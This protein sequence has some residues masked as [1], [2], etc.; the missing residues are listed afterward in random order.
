MQVMI[1]VYESGKVEHTCNLLADI[2]KKG[3]VTNLYDY[4]GN[5]LEINFLRNEVYF[6]KIWWTFPSKVDNF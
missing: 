6:N 3:E 4:N 5:E 1:I 2:N